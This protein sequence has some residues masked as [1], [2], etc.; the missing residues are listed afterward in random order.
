VNARDAMPI[1]G[2]LSIGVAGA[3]LDE[4]YA[5]GHVGVSPGS[6]VELLVSDT[7][8]GIDRET[9][10][11]VFEPFFT[12]KEPGKGTGLGLSTV[13]GIVRQSGGHIWLYSE[14]GIGT[15]FKIYLPRLDAA[16]DREVTPAVGDAPRGGHE[17]ILLVEDEAGVRLLARRILERAGYAVLE[18]ASAPEALVIVNDRAGEIDL[19]LT[20]VVMP[21]GFGSEVARG[22][23]AR[24][25][26]CVVIYMSGYAD[27]TIRQRGS[28]DAGAALVHKP[29]TGEALLGAVERALN[30]GE[31]RARDD[32][33]HRV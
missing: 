11:R 20:D 32:G 9:Q 23:A 8:V 6:Y 19:L 14:P 2:S 28:L 17:T 3:Q 1:G 21:G 31:R 16:G 5:E 24:N 18:A 13:D 29:F 10:S 22:L 33:E 15:S 26:S 30:S 7:G 25:P 12:T 27:E 4:A